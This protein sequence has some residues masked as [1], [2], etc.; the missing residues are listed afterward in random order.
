MSELPFTNGFPANIMKGHGRTHVVFLFLCWSEYVDQRPDRIELVQAAKTFVG[1]LKHT[2]KITDYAEQ[3]QQ[4]YDFHNHSTQYALKSF[5]LTYKGFKWLGVDNQMIPQNHGDKSL[6]RNPMLFNNQNREKFHDYDG[7]LNE[8]KLNWIEDNYKDRDIH[9]MLMIAHEQKEEIENILRELKSEEYFKAIVKSSFAEWGEKKINPKGEAIG[10]LEFRENLSNELDEKEIWK[11]VS[12][13][14]PILNAI[15]GSSS[16]GS[17]MVFRKL[18][19]NTK[20]FEQMVEDLAREIAKETK[21][22]KAYVHDLAQAFYMGR[23][24]DGTPVIKSDTPSALPEVLANSFRYEDSANL[25]D[26]KCPVSAHIRAANPRLHSNQYATSIIRRGIPYQHIQVD[27]NGEGQ[28]VKGIF[29]ISY[30]KDITSLTNILASM[31]A[32]RDAIAYRPFVGKQEVCEM[33]TNWG[34]DKRTS[35]HIGG[36]DLTIFRG[37]ESFFVPSTV[38]LEQLADAPILL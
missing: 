17:F 32:N 20:H 7:L 38:F 23:F 25:Q 2:F 14:E 8:K 18:E 37:G 29:F 15:A 34:K 1:K 21:A 36:N 35:L 27:A 28:V 5:F 6:F 16:Y 3:I 33:P 13:K 4:T 31:K 11:I 12:Y 19:V 9:A 24:K 30:Q 26:F 10:P 22:D